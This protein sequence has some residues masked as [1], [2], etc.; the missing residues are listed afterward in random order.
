MNARDPSLPIPS[1]ADDGAQALLAYAGR[2]GTSRS[3]PAMTDYIGV[4][5][6]SPMFDADWARHGYLDRA[7]RRRV[8]PGSSSSRLPGCAWRRCA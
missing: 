4:P 8:R 5:A 1:G 6:K 2:A 3:V 7:A